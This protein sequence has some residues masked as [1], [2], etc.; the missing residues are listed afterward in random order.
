MEEIRKVPNYPF[1]VSNQGD[2]Y[3][4]RGKPYK[5]QISN[6]GYWVFTTRINGESK[7]FLA[8]RLVA[9]A[10]LENPNNYPCVNHKDENPLNNSVDN[11]EWCTHKYNSNYGTAISRTRAKQLNSPTKSKPV[12]RI[13]GNEIV[14]YPSAKQAERDL[15]INNA[16]II[17][18]CL[19]KRKTAGGFMW[20][21]AT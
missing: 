19:G 14:K 12:L 7:R 18:C 20:G 8:H 11:L 10:F 6:N 2:V 17:A 13:N 5:L 3:N 1:F 9:M 21:Y 4:K 16:N 15:H